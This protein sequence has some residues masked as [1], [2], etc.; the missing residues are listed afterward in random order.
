MLE[1]K[2]KKFKKLKKV[3]I[4]IL[5]FF[6]IKEMIYLLTEDFS[7]ISFVFFEISQLLKYQ[8]S[9][10]VF[11]LVVMFFFYLSDVLF[12][13]VNYFW[14]IISLFVSL[15]LSFYVV[16]FFFLLNVDRLYYPRIKF[17]LISYN[18]IFTMI[19]FL[20]LFILNKLKKNK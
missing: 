4:F 1:I 13:K 8:I 7:P 14:K 19:F 3:A 18:I 20:A 15:I 6:L 5:L 16:S 17:F 11:T 10:L 2:T 12:D 9:I